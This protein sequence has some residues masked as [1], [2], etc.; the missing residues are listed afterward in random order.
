[1]KKKAVVNFESLKI[2]HNVPV[3][4]Q[5]KIVDSDAVKIL[6]KMKVGDSI[7][8]PEAL[9]KPMVAAAN[10]LRYRLKWVFSFR[11]LDKYDHR[12]WRLADGTVLRKKRSKQVIDTVDVLTPTR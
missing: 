11:R 12:V 6:E 4:R 2:E 10:T 3:Q 7:K 5:S 8:F 9:L 1:M